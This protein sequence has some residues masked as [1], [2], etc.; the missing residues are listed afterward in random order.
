[1][2][3]AQKSV[4]R[5]SDSHRRESRNRTLSRSRSRERVP[6]DREFGISSIK[7]RLGNNGDFRRRYDDEYDSRRGRLRHD[8]YEHEPVS[9][10]RDDK[11]HR[12]TL[13]IEPAKRNS[14]ARDN[15][16]VVPTVPV[17]KSVHERLGVKRTN[18]FDEFR[19]QQIQNHFAREPQ[20][21]QNFEIVEGIKGQGYE[22]LKD[23]DIIVISVPSSSATRNVSLG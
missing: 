14:S 19:T 2:K 4:V 22:D 11:V 16:Q 20:T 7:R 9:R 21:T 8:D 1:M 13:L 3:D 6:R 12:R 10:V 18:Y 23:D 5:D 17:R 15:E